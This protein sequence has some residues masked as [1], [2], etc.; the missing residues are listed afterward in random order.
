LGRMRKRF[1]EIGWALRAFNAGPA[2]VGPRNKKND[3]GRRS[4]EF[5]QRVLNTWRDLRGG[6][7]GEAD[8][9]GV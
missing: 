4:S 1:G 7:V 2:G 8:P 3:G 6:P 5:A 9:A